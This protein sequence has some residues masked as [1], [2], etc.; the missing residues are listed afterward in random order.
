MI[1][2][3]KQ[4]VFELLRSEYKVDR[5]I[6]AKDLQEKVVKQLEKLAGIKQADIKAVVKNDIQKLT[7]P[8]VHQGIAAETESVKIYGQNDLYQFLGKWDN[9][10]III[11]DQVQDPHNLGAILRTAEICNVHAV[12]MP[13]KGS[14]Q[15]N[16][17]VAKTSAGA[18]FHLNLFKINNLEKVIDEF[19]QAGIATMALMPGSQNTMYKKK[20]NE[21]VAIIVGSEGQ[22][23]RKNILG[24]CTDTISIPQFGKIESLNASVAAA[25]VL[26][27]VVRQR[28]R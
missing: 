17:T 5:V 14:A 13:E 19:K 4:P 21:P 27:E 16:D 7:G 18:L 8:V 1:V 6:Y 15:L 25:I 2:Y 26:Y 12:I 24:I 22:G 11:L 23:V 28:I 20:L 10:F 3:G 9:P